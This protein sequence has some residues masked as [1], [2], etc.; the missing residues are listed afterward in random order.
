MINIRDLYLE[1]IETALLDMGEKKY[2][3]KQIFAWL[4]RDVETFDEMTDLSKELIEKLKE[5]FYIQNLEAA[6]VQKSK[7]G[8]VKFLFRLQDGNAIESVMMKYKYG[9]TACVSNQ[10]GCKMGCTF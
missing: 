4:Y 7:D 10:V 9:N 8:T 3:A 5:K 2:R 6:N 1:E